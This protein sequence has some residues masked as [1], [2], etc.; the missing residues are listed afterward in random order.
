[1]T[2]DLILVVIGTIVGIL[3]QVVPGLKEKWEAWTWR[4]LAQFGACV[5]VAFALL[6][7][8]YAGAPVPF[9]CAMPFI[10]A[11]LWM[12]M[13]AA[14]AAY[15]AIDLGAGIVGGARLLVALRKEAKQKKYA[16]GCY[17]Q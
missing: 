14:L 11:G 4:R 17:K 9:G 15:A 6:G 1:M 16:R 10:W 5:I 12:A 7:L 2:A 3:F 8:C 13:S